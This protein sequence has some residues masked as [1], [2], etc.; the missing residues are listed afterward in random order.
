MWCVLIPINA[1]NTSRIQ[2]IACCSFYCRP[3][4]GSHAKSLLLDHISE[5]FQLLSV[6]YQKGLHFAIAGDAN[7]LKLDAILSLSQNMSQIVTDYTRMNPPKILDPIITTMASYYLK[8]ECLRPLD[9]DQDKIG[10]ASDHRIPVARPISEI[11][12]KS[13]RITRTVKVRSFPPSGIQKM[14]DWIGD[15]SWSNVYDAE[16]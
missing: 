7:T 14:E 13:A 10:K 16:S 9:V 1:T 2:K 8:P 4:S 5:V 15:E 3:S 11:S 12:S 6:K